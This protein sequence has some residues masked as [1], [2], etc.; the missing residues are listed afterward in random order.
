MEF[1]DLTTNWARKE[2]VQQKRFEQSVQV[3]QPSNE[4][5]T[6]AQQQVSATQAELS[7]AEGEVSSKEAVLNSANA[8]LN[9]AAATLASAQSRLG[10]IPQ[11]IKDE[12]TGEEK[13]NPEY[14]AAAQAVADA[15]EAYNTA[16]EEVNAAQR[17]LDAA[18]AKQQ[19]IQE[20]NQ[21]ALDELS[22]AQEE[23]D[24]AMQEYEAEME[25]QMEEEAEEETYDDVA[26]Q[27]EAT[28]SQQQGADDNAVDPMTITVDGVTYY[29]LD[30]ANKDRTDPEVT[31]DSATDDVDAMTDFFGSNIEELKKIAGDGGISLEELKELGVR[32]GEIDENGNIKVS[33]KTISDIIKAADG[34]IN[35]KFSIDEYGKEATQTQENRGVTL[36]STFETT[37]EFNEANKTNLKDNDKEA[38]GGKEY[39]DNPKYVDENGN[40]TDP[41]G[42][43]A[44]KEATVKAYLPQN[45]GETDA[46]YAKRVEAEMKNINDEEFKEFFSIDKDGNLMV[47]N[48]DY[49]NHGTAK[50]KADCPWNFATQI[51]GRSN[52]ANADKLF[53][54]IFGEGMT[55][56]GLA[57]KWN[58]NLNGSTEIKVEVATKTEAEQAL[59][60]VLPQAGGDWALND[61]EQGKLTF[62]SG[63]NKH[64]IDGL[65][66]FKANEN[67]TYTAKT[68]DGKD[69]TITPQNGGYVI[70]YPP[71]ENGTVIKTILTED[72]VKTE[73]VITHGSSQGATTTT[74]V[75]NGSETEG[76][77]EKTITE[78]ST[79]DGKTVTIVD[80]EGN[81]TFIQYD[82]EGKEVS[83]KQP[84]S[85]S[86]GAPETKTARSQEELKSILDD[87]S[88]AGKDHQFTD[89]ELNMIVDVYGSRLI[90][91]ALSDDEKFRAL[92]LMSE[93]DAAAFSSYYH[94]ERRETA[95]ALI[96]EKAEQYPDEVVKILSNISLVDTQ[97]SGED[98][99]YL[100]NFLSNYMNNNPDDKTCA[101][102]L[103]KQFNTAMVG[104]GKDKDFV[105]AAYNNMSE[106]AREAVRNA[107]QEKYG[108]SLTALMGNQV[109]LSSQIKPAPE[110]TESQTEVVA[111]KPQETE[112]QQPAEQT[113]QDVILS[114]IN[115]ME[116][117]GYDSANGFPIYTV[118]GKHYY[119]D[120]DGKP[121][122]SKNYTPYN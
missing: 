25:A 53:E 108:K 50:G 119:I 74:T 35:F 66:S 90:D 34:D 27:D 106:A 85:A 77:P 42:L 37:E 33:D 88:L 72:G 102:A 91:S 98:S 44:A 9:S 63:E 100:A 39:L 43:N 117:D 57:G 107:Y 32:L 38:T 109:G 17:E 99:E 1:L 68:S 45:E 49:W 84:S 51:F 23:Y 61:R 46:N 28:A 10:S 121:K 71:D 47:K 22:S 101:A 96:K 104:W 26:E 48:V 93:Q 103:A 118:D 4:Q 21:T 62:E 40:L 73:K 36:N 5:V 14:A 114:K 122:E 76:T 82:T 115:N 56:D 6:S 41:D 24:V 94:P 3:E 16:Q 78:T 54:A 111:E 83:R 81:K 105:I 7:G 79:K 29:L 18:N 13:E 116:A 11:T 65:K 70:E 89:E 75:Y 95:L 52:L 15:Q 64:E 80:K 92:S 30:P 112:A 60:D 59:E 67:G 113:E 97:T 31:F 87:K 8:T 19:T 86:P 12:E 55:V 58:A 110:T 69:V 120:V 2:K 20:N